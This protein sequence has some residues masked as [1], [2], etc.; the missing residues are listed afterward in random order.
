MYGDVIGPFRFN[1]ATGKYLLCCLLIYNSKEATKK[2]DCETKLRKVQG[3]ASI[4]DRRFIDNVLHLFVFLLLKEIRWLW[5]FPFLSSSQANYK[6]YKLEFWINDQCIYLFLIECLH[7]VLLPSSPSWSK[8]ARPLLHIHSLHS[9]TCF[10]FVATW[11]NATSSLWFKGH[12]NGNSSEKTRSPH[13]FSNRSVHNG[14][15]CFTRLLQI[16]V[17]EPRVIDHLDNTHEAKRR[18]IYHIGI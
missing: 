1:A 10:L 3:E 7:W 4:R 18:S 6:S 11:S 8:N 5:P 17:L 9:C 2:N 15:C 14:N 16:I 12:E 13:F